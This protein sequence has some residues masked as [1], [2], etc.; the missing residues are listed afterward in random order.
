M[1]II[2]ELI[3]KTNNEGLKWIRQNPTTLYINTRGPEGTKAVISLQ[4]VISR[5]VGRVGDKIIRSAISFVFSVKNISS[6]ELVVQ[7]DSNVKGNYQEPFSELFGIANYSIEK[8]SI[9]YIK[10]VLGNL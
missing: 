5:R 2:T 9:D 8:R 4:K 3:N 7:I 10:G 1:G 6:N